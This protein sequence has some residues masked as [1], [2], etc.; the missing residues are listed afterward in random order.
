[1]QRQFESIV[2]A[3]TYRREL[4]RDAARVRPIPAINS[5]EG[6]ATGVRAGSV[7]TRAASIL[8]RR[9]LG[10]LLVRVGQLL[11][12]EQP[13]AREYCGPTPT[14]EVSASA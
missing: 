2:L 6:F 10:A 7:V 3:D 14:G 8:L 4:L 11:Q 1:M 13:G 9:R 12:G 5:P